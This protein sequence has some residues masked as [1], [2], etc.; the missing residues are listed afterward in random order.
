[1]QFE[2]HRPDT[3]KD[4]HAHTNTYPTDCCTQPLKWSATKACLNDIR[5]N[6][7]AGSNHFYVVKT[8]TS[9]VF[10][11]VVFSVRE[12]RRRNDGAKRAPAA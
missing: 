12:L 6:T 3:E 7:L 1:M 8:S 5:L 4:A 2:S 11:T 9:N 10:S